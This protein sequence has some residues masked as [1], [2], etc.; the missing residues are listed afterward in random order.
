MGAER[1]LST[2]PSFPGSGSKNRKKCVQRYHRYRFQNTV[3]KP[4]GFVWIGDCS[5]VG[6][7]TL[8]QWE[9]RLNRMEIFRVVLISHHERVQ[10]S[11]IVPYHR[12]RFEQISFSILISRFR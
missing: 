11:N 3:G 7:L 4:A 12:L 10:N 8:H 6:L 1:D 5:G 9:D 2:V